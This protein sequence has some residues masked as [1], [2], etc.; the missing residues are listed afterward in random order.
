MLYRGDRVY[1]QRV[2][3]SVVPQN[4]RERVLKLAHEV[5]AHLG[6]R[7]TS[8]R[9][10]LSFWWNGIKED[11]R[12]L[13]SSCHSCQLRHRLRASDRVP[14]TPISRATRP[15]EMIVIDVIGPIEPATSRSSE[16]QICIMYCGF[17][18]PFSKCLLA[19]GFNGKIYMPSFARILLNFLGRH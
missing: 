14:I 3:Q 19:K 7:R 4:R 5:G 1:G 16:V 13:V 2:W 8:E 11:V 10:R 15:L 18:F 6:I 12:K 17:I 9:I